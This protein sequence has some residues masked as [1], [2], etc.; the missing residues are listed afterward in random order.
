VLRPAPGPVSAAEASSNWS[1]YQL[2]DP[3]AN[4]VEGFWTVPA[5]TGNG[6]NDYESTWVGLGGGLNS[7]SGDLLQ[8]GTE[9]DV[10]SSGA[11]AYHFW[12]EDVPAEPTEL[13]VTNLVPNPGD[14]VAAATAWDQGSGGTWFTTL[15][16]WT[17]NTCVDGSMI[18]NPPGTS[19][20]WIVERP[21]INNV[22]QPLARYVAETFSN[23]FYADPGSQQMI[24]LVNGNPTP[25]FMINSIDD[26]LSDPGPIDPGGAS[27]STDWVAF[28]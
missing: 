25:I 23:C 12:I 21:S 13:Q 3:S 11:T 20:E 6:Q 28:S 22:P 24:P 17:Q 8:D 9:S 5:V 14:S 1:G 27:F 10:A 19:V 2:T 18:T 26:P 4:Q 15:C 7:G 16:D